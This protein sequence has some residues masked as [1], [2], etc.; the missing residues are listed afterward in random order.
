MCQLLIRTWQEKAGKLRQSLSSINLFTFSLSEHRTRA[1]QA[2][3]TLLLYGRE[4]GCDGCDV[5]VII[6]YWWQDTGLVKRFSGWSNHIQFGYESL[7]LGCDQWDK[8]LEV[9]NRGFWNQ[10]RK[11]K[12]F[13]LY[14]GIPEDLFS[15]LVPVGDDTPAA[16]GCNR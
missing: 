14:L 16:D 15:G 6:C 7:I 3:R 8:C 10:F 5:A 1:P 11:I 13:C 12:L 9:K 4:N 2:N